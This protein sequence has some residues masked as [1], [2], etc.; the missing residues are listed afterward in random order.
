VKRDV[1]GRRGVEAVGVV[2]L[3][4]ALVV[5]PAAC[6]AIAGIDAPVARA[7]S[8]GGADAADESQ[9]TD[10]GTC[11]IG[12]LGCDSKQP[13]ICTSAGWQSVGSSCPGACLRGACVACT[14]GET[15]CEGNAILVCGAAGDWNV[16]A[17]APCQ[18]SNTCI[19]VEGGAQCACNAGCMERQTGTGGNTCYFEEVCVPVGCTQDAV[20]Y[21]AA[22]SQSSCTCTMGDA[23]PVIRPCDGGCFPSGYCATDPNGADLSYAICGY[24]PLGAL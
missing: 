6:A 19:P 14:P 9:P 21:N 17:M 13:V 22:C 3:S 23:A 4:L 7:D 20:T 5:P 8:D 2:V 16:D 12:A 10:A 15:T 24:P 18:G 1:S 11:S